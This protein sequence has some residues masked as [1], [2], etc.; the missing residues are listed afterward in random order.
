METLDYFIPSPLRGAPKPVKYLIVGAEAYGAYKLGKYAY[1]KL[2][3]SKNQETVTSVK[4]EADE[5][6]KNNLHLPPSEQTIP[7]YSK[8]QYKTFADTLETAM[9][10]GG[11]DEAA[12]L[13]VFKKMNNDLDMLFLIE[14]FGTREGYSIFGTDPTN[15]AAWLAGDGMTQAVNKLLET[16]SKI[17]K[18][19]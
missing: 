9:Y 3:P 6:L 18:R 11:T 17:T 19:F 10:G 7:S 16:K 12:V 4:T 5:I 8:A 1:K 2:N 14:Q 15:L 13:D